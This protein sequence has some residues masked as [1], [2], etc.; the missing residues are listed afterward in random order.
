MSI[1]IYVG[2]LPF[3]MSEDDLRE[4]F[5]AYGDVEKAKIISDP[6]SGKSKGFGF[7]EMTSQEAGNQAIKELNG[8]EVSGRGIVVSEARPRKNKDSFQR[9]KAARPKS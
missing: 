8:K 5:A 2:N 1:N 3:R 9:S 6:Q 4:L 7:V